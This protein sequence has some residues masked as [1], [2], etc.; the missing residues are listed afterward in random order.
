MSDD[1]I[2]RVEETVPSFLEFAKRYL[3]LIAHKRGLIFKVKIVLVDAYYRLQA[4][5]AFRVDKC[6]AL[7]D[8]GTSEVF[9][10][11]FQV[12]YCLVYHVVYEF[13]KHIY[14]LSYLHACLLRLIE[15]TVAF[16][17]NIDG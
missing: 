9:R 8:F 16:W 2:E 6:R 14:I 12:D 15:D 3:E 1:L 17:Y 11:R 13:A 5:H 10:N 4:V 7:P